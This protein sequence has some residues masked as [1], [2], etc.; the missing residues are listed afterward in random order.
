LFHLLLYTDHDS[1]QHA[2]YLLEVERTVAPPIPPGDADD[3]PGQAIA[4]G[5]FLG[6]ADG[7]LDP[8]DAYNLRLTAGQEL[9]IWMS[10]PNT[11]ILHLLSPRATSLFGPNPPTILYETTTGS[12]PADFSPSDSS[13]TISYQPPVSG[14]YYLS[15]S[16]YG[17]VPYKMFVEGAAEPRDPDSQVFPDV[18][19]SSPHADAIAGLVDTGVISG[20]SDGSF[21]PDSQVMR[22][23]ITKIICESL[24]LPVR[25]DMF[26]H[27]ADLGPDDVESV[28]PHEY[29]AAGY[30][31]GVVKGYVGFNFGP[32]RPVL[33]AQAVTMVTRAARSLRAS[34]LDAPP[35]GFNSQLGAFNDGHAEGM[36]WA[37]YNGLLT[38]LPGYGKSWDPWL[39]M[40]R[41]EV[42]ELVW[43]LLERGREFNQAR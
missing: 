32:Y 13:P 17:N 5:W 42:A 25:E 12:L 15:V 27:F 37:E 9:K 20:F 28:Y 8:H 6:V 10:A 35:S 38:G 40:S 4:S 39:P 7:L 1:Q 21:R 18:P 36:A 43:R 26:V 11:A 16:A 33:R 30:Q 24:E 29:I 22:A 23:Q 2:R 41:G 3:L 34:W 31:A 19:V 14:V